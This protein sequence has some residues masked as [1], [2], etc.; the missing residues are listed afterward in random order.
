MSISKEFAAV[1]INNLN[2]QGTVSQH[3]H[4]FKIAPTYTLTQQL[5]G[6]TST[7]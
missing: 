5:P 4:M 3:S 1:P 6:R 7:S 2:F